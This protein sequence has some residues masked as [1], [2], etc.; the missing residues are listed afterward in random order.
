MAVT[1][2]R[3]EGREIPCEARRGDGSPVFH[4]TD[5]HGHD[6]YHYSDIEAAQ[7][8]VEISERERAEHIGRH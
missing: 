6:E 8:V 3:L 2:K 5:E 7:R 1:I 4:V